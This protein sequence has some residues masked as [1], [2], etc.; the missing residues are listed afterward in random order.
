MSAATLVETSRIV[1]AI[2]PMPGSRR[3]TE[4]MTT[5]ATTKA[6]EI[7]VESLMPRAMPLIIANTNTRPMAS[8]R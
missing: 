2:R 7:G 8:I 3:P 6:E 5:M 1:P 4:A